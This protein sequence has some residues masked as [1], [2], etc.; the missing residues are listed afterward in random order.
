MKAK[1]CFQFLVHLY[2][3]ERKC[4]ED[5]L[6]DKIGEE[7]IQLIKVEYSLFFKSFYVWIELKCNRKLFISVIFLWKKKRK[8]LLNILRGYKTQDF[9]G[10]VCWG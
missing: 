10:W 9:S 3:A 1:L 8:F 5:Y 6:R 7:N 2:E 4:F